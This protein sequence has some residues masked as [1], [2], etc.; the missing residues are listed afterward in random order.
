MADNIIKRLE[1]LNSVL[2]DAHLVQSR[3]SKKNLCFIVGLP[4]VGSTL[5]QQVLISR[6]NIGYVSNITGKFWKNAVA[7]TIVHASLAQ[8]EYISN[9]ISEYGNTQGPFE[10]CE[11]GWFWQYVLNIDPENETVGSQIDW[12]H[13]NET[14]HSMAEV[15]QQTMIFDTPFA[16][17]AISDFY[18]HLER[19]KVI[20]L[21]RNLQ[22]I[23]NSI[24]SARIKRYGDINRYY[25]AKPKSWP[26]IKNIE[27]PILQVVR[28]V[29][30]LSQ[31][32][33]DE[34]SLINP[35]NIFTLDVTELRKEPSKIADKI[36]YFL[37]V[38]ARPQNVKFPQF[39]DR[40]NVPF[41]NNDF[42]KDFDD[43]WNTV[44][45]AS[46]S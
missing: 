21:T 4:R 11:F 43:A 1:K 40:D 28:Q 44:F 45:G 23:A 26:E 46:V 19:V 37:D 39:S 29:H 18:A 14:L 25:G 8:S 5:L 20:H 42:K 16:C 30:D 35:E 3:S 12:T 22:S 41:F 17:G 34:L 38:D 31:D 10:P 7:G 33:K 27:D 36:A 32:I 13:L 2:R 9:L 6:Y 15:F 24:Y